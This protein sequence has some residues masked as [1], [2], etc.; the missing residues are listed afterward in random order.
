MSDTMT[1]DTLMTGADAQVLDA[2]DPLRD[3]RDRFHIPRHDGTE[4]AYFCGN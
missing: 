2:A 4:M 1:T 3:F